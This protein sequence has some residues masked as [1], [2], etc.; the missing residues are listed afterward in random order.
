MAIHTR[1][2]SSNNNNDSRD[3]RLAYEMA[4]RYLV[5]NSG[6]QATDTQTDSPTPTPLNSV[7]HTPMPS[8]R[9]SPRS[10][11]DQGRPEHDPLVFDRGVAGNAAPTLITT[12]RVMIVTNIVLYFVLNLAMTFLNKLVMLQVSPIPIVCLI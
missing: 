6:L 1:T 2:R 3:S 7:V 10:S 11:E 9:P 5:T 12:S 8:A 4:S